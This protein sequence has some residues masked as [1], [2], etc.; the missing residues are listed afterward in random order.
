LETEIPNLIKGADLLAGTSTGGI[1]AL[2]LA[3]G[4]SVDEMMA[5]YKDNGEQIFDETWFDDLRDLGGLAGADYDQKNLGE[6]L[7]SEFGGI[8]LRDLSKRVLIP[9]FNLDDGDP[10]AAK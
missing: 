2:G 5:L 3:A 10:D 6:I 9:T 7:T 8:R 1:I 4:R